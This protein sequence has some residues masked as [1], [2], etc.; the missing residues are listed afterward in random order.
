M[1]WRVESAN[2]LASADEGIFADTSAGTFTVTLPAA[3]SLGDRVGISDEASTFSANNLTVARNGSLIQGLAEDLT[4]DVAD[5]SFV[6]IYSGATTGWKIDTYLS[7]ATPSDWTPGTVAVANYDVELD[8]PA[9]VLHVT[10][11]AA[12][13][14]TIRFMS[15]WLA[16]HGNHITIKDTGRNASVNNI[17]ITTEG[18]EQIEGAATA[19][20]IGDGDSLTL[21]AYSGNLFVI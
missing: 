7:Q 10:Q 20:M 5:A 16:V 13:V 1:V 15:A 11:T 17:T 2:Y 3:P 12:G 8:E 14:C 19:T 18:A 6:L 9:R 21:Q 4:V